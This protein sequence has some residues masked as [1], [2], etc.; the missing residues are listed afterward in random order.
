[1]KQHPHIH[2]YCSYNF[3]TIIRNPILLYIS[4]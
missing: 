2:H 1:M 4:I 3:A